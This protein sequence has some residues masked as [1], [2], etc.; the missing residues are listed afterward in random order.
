MPKVQA[1]RAATQVFAQLMPRPSE[2]RLSHRHIQGFAARVPGDCCP[3]D[4]ARLQSS[5]THL[6]IFC[7]AEA[8][9]CCGQSL[10][11]KPQA[12]TQSEQSTTVGILRNAWLRVV[13]PYLLCRE[14]ESGLRWI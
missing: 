3:V 14:I 9:E 11:T 12:H 13:C 10:V 1:R 2:V 6:Q 4:P 5:T 7:P 8:Y